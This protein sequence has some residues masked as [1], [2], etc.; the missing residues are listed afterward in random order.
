MVTNLWKQLLWNRRNFLQNYRN[1]MK[2]KVESFRTTPH[3]TGS[4]C[5]P[6]FLCLSTPHTFLKCDSMFSNIN[7]S[8]MCCMSR[9]TRYSASGVFANHGARKKQLQRKSELLAER[10][11]ARIVS[12]KRE[13][14]KNVDKKMS[15]LVWYVFI[16]FQCY[17]CMWV[18]YLGKMHTGPPWRHLKQNWK[19]LDIFW[20]KG[21]FTLPRHYLW[22]C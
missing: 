1:I 8:G 17:W 15:E 18:T 6:Q 16:H 22:Y 4:S 13:T 20:G 10:L 5:I 12:A 7:Y 11:R 14:R 2:L 9:W 21:V 19:N 3:R